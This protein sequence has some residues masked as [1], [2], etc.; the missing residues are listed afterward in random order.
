MFLKFSLRTQTALFHAGRRAILLAGVEHIA[1]GLR[2][3]REDKKDGFFTLV[4][5]AI[6]RYGLVDGAGILHFQIQVIKNIHKNLLRI[7]S[8]IQDSRCGR[9]CQGKSKGDAD[10]KGV[11]GMEEKT[12]KTATET[13]LRKQVELLAQDGMCGERLDETVRKISALLMVLRAA[14]GETF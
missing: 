6:D 3:L 1:E 2:M 7:A 12:L 11:R 8:R 4:F 13:A 14:N 10:W 5:V 9:R